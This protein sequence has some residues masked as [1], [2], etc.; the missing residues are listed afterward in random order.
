LYWTGLSMFIYHGNET[1][2]GAVR[3]TTQAPNHGRRIS[4]HDEKIF[5]TAIGA[6]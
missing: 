1:E 2:I 3:T 6:K 4:T 5:S